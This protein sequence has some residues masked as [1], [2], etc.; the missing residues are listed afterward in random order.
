MKNLKKLGKL[1]SLMFK[2][3]VIAVKIKWLDLKA[4]RLARK[5]WDNLNQAELDEIYDKQMKL[6]F[7]GMFICLDAERIIKETER[8]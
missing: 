4:N 3:I 7:E 8:A 6:S 1:I 5:G 2:C